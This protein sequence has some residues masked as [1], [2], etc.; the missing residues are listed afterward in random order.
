[1]SSNPWIWI[2]IRIKTN[3]DPQ[4]WRWMTNG[5]PVNLIKTDGKRFSPANSKFS[6]VYY[7]VVNI[8]GDHHT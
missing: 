2:R 3:A 5:G 6:F 8:F 7:R 4:H 1:M